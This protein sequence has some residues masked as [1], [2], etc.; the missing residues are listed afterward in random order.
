MAAFPCGSERRAGNV[1]VSWTPLGAS[2]T[3]SLTTDAPLG[4]GNPVALKINATDNQ[5][6][7]FVTAV[8]D[9][10]L[11]VLYSASLV[12]CVKPVQTVARLRSVG[13]ACV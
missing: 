2:S 4:P 7:S 11:V 3:L 10:S 1:P 9:L 5:V 13:E 8:E 12:D 6:S